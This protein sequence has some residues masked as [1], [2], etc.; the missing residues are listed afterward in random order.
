M[1]AGEAMPALLSVSPKLRPVL[2][3]EFVPASL[4]NRAYRAAVRASGGGSNLALALER[5]DGSVSVYRTVIPPHTGEHVAV[6]HRYVERLLKILLW[7]KGGFRVTVGGDAR[8]ADFLRA[9][10]AQ[11]GIRDFD[12]QFMG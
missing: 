4:W 10:Y 11:G 6:T 5:S 8:I 12:R 2:D 3:P 7:Q 9:A 1:R